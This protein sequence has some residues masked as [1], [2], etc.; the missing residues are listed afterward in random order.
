MPTLHLEAKKLSQK[1]PKSQA[2]FLMPQG[3]ASRRTSVLVAAH[4]FAAAQR[5]GTTALMAG[6]NHS[7][8]YLGQ[9]LGLGSLV[10]QA[11]ARCTLYVSARV[12]KNTLCTI[13]NLKI[14]K[15]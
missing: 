4:Q 13:K 6:Y 12:R 9:N 11:F 3:I 1:K 2:K 8:E 5:L 7:Q 10:R 15:F 14:F